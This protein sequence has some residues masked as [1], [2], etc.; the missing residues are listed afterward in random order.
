VASSLFTSISALEGTVAQVFET[1][2][3]VPGRH[4]TVSEAEV[5]QLQIYN[6]YM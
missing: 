5:K 6:G 4:V 1:H 2:G 3:A